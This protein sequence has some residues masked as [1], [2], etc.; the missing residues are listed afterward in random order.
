MLKGATYS[1]IHKDLAKMEPKL[2]GVR[3]NKKVNLEQRAM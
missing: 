1:H 3:Q 2:L